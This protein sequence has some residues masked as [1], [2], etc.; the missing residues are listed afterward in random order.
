LE[1]SK[2]K[3]VVLMR[4]GKDDGGLDMTP[5]ALEISREPFYF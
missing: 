4:D 3:V 5:E 1:A 2:G